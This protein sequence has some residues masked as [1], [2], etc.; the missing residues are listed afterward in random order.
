M[1]HWQEWEA[2]KQGMCHVKAQQEQQQRVL[3]CPYLFVKMAGRRKEL[4]LLA[5]LSHMRESVT[6]TLAMQRQEQ[7]YVLYPAWA[8]QE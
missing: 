2:A 8:Q 7:E 4:L 5:A 1:E 3:S 6:V